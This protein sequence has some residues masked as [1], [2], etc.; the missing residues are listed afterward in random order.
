VTIEEKKTLHRIDPK[1]TWDMFA[2]CPSPV[3]PRWL[4]EHTNKKGERKPK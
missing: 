2:A 3:I 1:Y 4:L